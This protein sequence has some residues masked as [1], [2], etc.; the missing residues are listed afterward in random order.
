MSRIVSGKI[1]LDVQPVELP[2]VIHN[3]V[4]TVQPAA[5]ARGVR[6]RP[7]SIRASA[8]V[9][10]DPDRLQQVVWNLLSNAVK[11]T[12]KAGRVQVRLERVELARRD[13]RQRHRHRHPPEFLPYVFERF[14]QADAG[15]DAQDR[16]PRAGAVDRPP[17]R[18]DARRHRGG[19]EPGRGQG[20]DVPRP[21]AADDRARRRGCASR[22]S[23]RAPS[24]P[25]PPDRTGRTQRR[26]R[27]GDR[28]RG[29]RAGAAPRRAR[30][31]RRGGDD[32]VVGG[33]GA[34]ADRGD[35]ARCR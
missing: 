24:G 23:I 11:F 7:S 18:R 17:H 2:L 3:A 32:A 4:A 30:D 29:G 19:D 1:R 8:P 6:S 34:G 33:R 20:R 26:P 31:G 13:H 12:P 9:S 22:A 5:D 28:R 21:A 25:T 15:H 10:G 14:R 35:P 16:R 27:A